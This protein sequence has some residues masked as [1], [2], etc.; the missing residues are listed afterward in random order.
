MRLLTLVTNTDF[1]AFAKARPLDDAKFA[2]LVALVR[3]E[4]ALSS[5]WVCKDEFPG[6]WADHDG[7][8]ITGSPASVNA[9]DSWM[10]RLETLIREIVDRGVPLFGACFGHQIIAK[11]LG[12]PIVRNP[13]G[14]AH[15]AIDV[16]RVQR[17]PWS[18]ADETFTLYGSHSEQVGSLPAGADRIFESPGCPIAGYAIGRSVFTIQHHPEM[19]QD[20][21]SDLVE[22]YSDHVGPQ[23]TETARRSIADRPVRRA[24]FAEEIAAFF[25]Q[26]RH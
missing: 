6:N 26:G 19:T 22:E 12:A 9:A 15:G 24:L 13:D 7:I 8:L 21:I 10:T 14:W 11:A 2:A 1:S 16:T 4:W 25:E 20:F 18:A 3:P 5:A 23:V 17:T